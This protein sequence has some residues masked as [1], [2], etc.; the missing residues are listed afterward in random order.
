MQT[1]RKDLLCLLGLQTSPSENN[2]GFIQ[3]LRKRASRWM[4][5]GHVHSKE[6]LLRET[7]SIRLLGKKEDQGGDR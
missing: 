1:A 5:Q 2:N 6:D 3:D 7:Q 4:D